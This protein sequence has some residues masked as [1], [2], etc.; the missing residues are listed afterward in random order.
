MKTLVLVAL[1]LTVPDAAVF[2][3]TVRWVDWTSGTAE[4]LPRSPP[5]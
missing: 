4:V 5:R 1:T 3:D 2:V